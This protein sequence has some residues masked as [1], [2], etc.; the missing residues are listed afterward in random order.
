M[1]DKKEV[2][3]TSVNNSSD[4]QSLKDHYKKALTF[5]EK[6]DYVN[7]NEEL[8][9][10]YRLNPNSPYFYI[11]KLL[12]E[13]GF[14]S[15]NELKEK[16]DS[17]VTSSQFFINAEKFADGN[18]KKF[19]DSLKHEVVLKTNNEKL[20]VLSLEQ[21]LRLYKVQKDNNIDS[22]QTFLVINQNLNNK[23][24]YVNADFINQNGLD[25]AFFARLNTA[26]SA[27]EECLN[28]LKNYS[29]ISDIDDLANQCEEENSVN[30]R[31]ILSFISKNLEAYQEM[32][33]LQQA[34]DYISR[35]YM[36]SDSEFLLQ[37]I[38]GLLS[39][40]GDGQNKLRGKHLGLIVT[41]SVL[42][43]SF[44][45]LACGAGA[46]FVLTNSTTVDGVKYVKN[47]TGY[48][49]S[50][51]DNDYL[52]K[53]NGI[54]TLKSEIGGKKVTEISRDAFY[55]TNVKEVK[56]FP[57]T[58]TSIPDNA[59]YN[60]SYLE[61]VEITE[62]SS[63]EVIGD[64]AFA[65]CPLLTTLTL[66]NSLKKIGAN[67]F[68]HCEA[69]DN[70][71]I[72]SSVTTIGNNAFNDTEELTHLIN[73]SNIS[74]KEGARVGL[75]LRTITIVPGEGG[76][77]VTSAPSTYYSWDTISLPF[78][79][80]QDYGTFKTYDIDGFSGEVS[81]EDNVIT[82]RP[83]GLKSIT[84]TAVY[85]YKTSFTYKNVTYKLSTDQTHYI[86]DKVSE[87]DENNNSI[88]NI[89]IVSNF[90]DK[91]VTEI[92]PDAF[93]NNKVIKIISNMSSNIEE[94]PDY[95]FEGCSS[96]TNITFASVEN[97][98]LT[99]IGTNAFAGCTSLEGIEIPKSV[100]Y[101][102][103]NAFYN[104]PNLLS[105]TNYS[106]M[107]LSGSFL[108]LTLRNINYELN[109]IDYSKSTLKQYYYVC[110][111]EIEIA[112]PTQD[113]KKI[114]TLLVNEVNET[115]DSNNVIKVSTSNKE[116]ISIVATY[117]Y[118][119][120]PNE[121][122]KNDSKYGLRICLD[123]ASKFTGSTVEFNYIVSLNRER[124]SSQ[125]IALS[126][127][128][129]VEIH[130]N[131]N[132]GTEY[133]V[134]IDKTTGKCSFVAGGIDNITITAKIKTKISNQFLDEDTRT[135]SIVNEN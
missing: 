65:N 47:D 56:N 86:I 118:N 40:R 115:P 42:G 3:D 68:S 7:A 76:S 51:I 97:S 4:Y 2:L 60:C 106:N 24:R 129:D 10:I 70:L 27:Y 117:E 112:L 5:I 80:T 131:G 122:G 105:F 28:Y 126:E 39:T 125:Q 94:I 114:A 58:I 100:T 59:F 116:S 81:R 30:K 53:Y 45:S 84:A 101:I 103:Q 73:N 134:T 12:I 91:K 62:N 111:G 20:K 37:R 17:R 66:P 98:K 124:N 130:V 72:P 110:D 108:G 95:A 54:I 71:I 1:D 15:V 75:T 119:F 32:G 78:C 77:T 43:V 48:T 11:A 79:N 18:V 13:F 82:F 87:K 36:S 127:F 135:L 113:L 52:T 26:D 74:S 123:G 83:S 44:A 50:S 29:D 34:K 90:G 64:S 38:D 89:T 93:K 41:T 49:I 25:E 9:F 99:R 61:R 6:R 104:T 69:I 102:G 132:D 31:Y 120:T 121:R 21:L 14:T 109:N 22:N 8:E 23:F 19:L 133:S 128:G 88:T 33:C 92:N 55:S 63:L 35:N 85:D 67:A 16:S 107:N 57:D 96:L 46:Y